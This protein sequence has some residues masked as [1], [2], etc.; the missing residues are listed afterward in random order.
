MFGNACLNWISWRVV[1]QQRD[2]PGVGTNVPC[3]SSDDYFEDVV[4]KGVYSSH[5]SL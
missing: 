3:V 2:L 4:Y 5:A 1:P